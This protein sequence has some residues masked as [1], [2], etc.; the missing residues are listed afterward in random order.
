MNAV[1]QMKYYFYM[2]FQL[3]FKHFSI[4]CSGPLRAVDQT[5]ATIQPS[6]QQQPQQTVEI[7]NANNK[8]NTKSSAQNPQ[9]Q[10][11]GDDK[12]QT[13]DTSENHIRSDDLPNQEVFGS[14]VSLNDYNSNGNRDQ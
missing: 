3:L 7:K 13:D 11:K 8:I 14:L 1:Q 2:Y 5:I 9:I 4:A 12:H 10:F 6:E